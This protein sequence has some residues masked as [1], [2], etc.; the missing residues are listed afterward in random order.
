[1]EK[2]YEY[3]YLRMKKFHEYS[4]FTVENS[5]KY[6]YYRIKKFMF[7]GII[8]KKS[9]I[10]IYKGKHGYQIFCNYG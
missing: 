9:L 10:E 8:L 3:K 1:M 4:Y 2:L 7:M 6:R 5:Y